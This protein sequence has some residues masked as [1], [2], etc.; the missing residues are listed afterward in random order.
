MRLNGKTRMKAFA[1]ISLIVCMIVAQFALATQ[2]AESPELSPDRSQS[3]FLTGKLIRIR[4]YDQLPED[5]VAY[6]VAE[7]PLEGLSAPFASLGQTVDRTSLI[8]IIV[9][10]A[11]DQQDELLASF[12]GDAVFAEPYKP[13][14]TLSL[15]ASSANF[16]G[17]PNCLWAFNDALGNPIAGAHVDVYIKYRVSS[18][19]RPFLPEM[20]LRR[21][22]LDD[23][24]RMSPV[25]TCSDRFECKLRLSHPDYRTAWAAPKG[26][27]PSSFVIPGVPKDMDVREQSVWGTVVDTKD[28]PI[29]GCVIECSGLTVPGDV[30]KTVF[31]G[32]HRA[33]SDANGAFFMT[34][35]IRENTLA[36]IRAVYHLTVIYPSNTGSRQS[37]RVH[38]TPCTLRINVRPDY[39]H[40]FA[41]EDAQGPITDPR[42]LERINLS[43][44]RPLQTTITLK[45]DRFKDGCYLPCGMYQA[46]TH[47]ADVPAFETVTVD[48]NS[49]AHIVFTPKSDEVRRGRVL[50]AVTGLPVHRAI[51]MN[52]TPESLSSDFSEITP[53]QWQQIRLLKD[54]PP[55]DHPALEP[56]RGICRRFDRVLL[57]DEQGGF[58]FIAD[59]GEVNICLTVAREGY[60]GYFNIFRIW[61]GSGGMGQ[62]D[63]NARKK[64]AMELFSH[65]Y[66]DSD[67]VVIVPTIRLFPAAT[68]RFETYVEDANGPDDSARIRA[69]WNYR[70][71]DETDWRSAF[72]ALTN[73]F[74]RKFDAN[75]LQTM[76]VPAGIEVE[77]TLYMDR[78]RDKSVRWENI[79]LP[80]ITGLKQ[81]EVR[82]LDVQ[83][84]ERR[85]PPVPVLVKVIDSR[86][87]PVLGV[88]ISRLQDGHIGG[89]NTITDKDGIARFGITQDTRGVFLVCCN[90]PSG[91]F[92]ESAP[93]EVGGMEDAETVFTLQLSDRMIDCLF[94]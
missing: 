81:N 77:I 60:M 85:K 40:T 30:G 88:G 15:E 63:A 90:P 25:R 32:R 10:V 45:Y 29:P 59:Q 68:I 58:Q 41:F 6:K 22:T 48:S 34:P 8:P 24:A 62:T 19:Y 82:N 74:K 69:H 53:R 31:P 76:H 33:I 78:C 3:Q 36:P 9:A 51:V 35:P 66:K 54:N 14:N 56:L 52:A 17:D 2:Q 38:E 55:P 23:G 16:A 87:L 61:S 71:Y 57:T 49:P 20:Y 65:V 73:A 5:P 94:K 11:E 28:N 67:R 91:W 80:R 89:I 37:F 84:F 1:A 93:Y 79:V 21:V 70:D 86:G 64:P 43:I 12:M 4:I 39:F 50:D 27:P 44:S 42:R 46:I 75:T 72:S 13:E 18:T 7:L 26:K 92:K 47:Y 83:V